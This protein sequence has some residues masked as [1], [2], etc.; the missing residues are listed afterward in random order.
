LIA[1]KKRGI[2]HP[3]SQEFHPFATL[4]PWQSDIE[5][6][7]WFGERK[8]MWSQP[9]LHFLAQQLPNEIFQRYAPLRSATLTFRST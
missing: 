2:D 9:G 3:A 7:A 5:F 1:S 6:K 8:E 4:D